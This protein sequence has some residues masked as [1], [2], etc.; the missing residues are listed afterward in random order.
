MDAY[1]LMDSR[2]RLQGFFKE[3]RNYMGRA[4]SCRDS[5]PNLIDGVPGDLKNVNPTHLFPLFAFKKSSCRCE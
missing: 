2:Q 3:M 1:G 4:P 5:K